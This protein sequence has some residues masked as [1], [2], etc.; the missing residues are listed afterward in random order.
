MVKYLRRWEDSVANAPR[1]LEQ[2]KPNVEDHDN[3]LPL[4]W[5]EF[6]YARTNAAAGRV[7]TFA[8]AI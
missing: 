6:L 4:G 5:R 8:V 7:M 3:E 1:H 2:N